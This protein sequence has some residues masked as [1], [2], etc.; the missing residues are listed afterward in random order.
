MNV[1][2]KQN[3]DPK[4]FYEAKIETGKFYMNNLLPETGYLV[5]SIMSGAK[6]YNQYDDAYFETGFLL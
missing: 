3:D 4:G 6:S 2:I 1:A 5:S